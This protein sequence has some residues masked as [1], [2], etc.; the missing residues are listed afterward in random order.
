MTYMSFA[1][2]AKRQATVSMILTDITSGTASKT[3]EAEFLQ[4]IVARGSTTLP[5]T[6]I[7]Q[8]PT[9]RDPGRGESLDVI[10]AVCVYGGSA[11]FALNSTGM[12]DPTIS[13]APVAALLH[14]SIPWPAYETKPAAF[15]PIGSH[16]GLIEVWNGSRA[17]NLPRQSADGEFSPPRTKLAELLLKYRETVRQAGQKFRSVDEILADL[18]RARNRFRE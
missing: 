14:Q 6:A 15:H 5:S 3:P 2:E 8:S 12:G 7:V 4:V 13:E 1:V 17:S 11:L 18:Q 10:R 9:L 16:F